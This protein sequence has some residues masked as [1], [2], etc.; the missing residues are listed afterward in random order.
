MAGCSREQ[1]ALQGEV[2]TVILA[3][4]QQTHLKLTVICRLEFFLSGPALECIVS[5]DVYALLP[6]VIAWREDDARLHNSQ[7]VKDTLQPLLQHAYL[8]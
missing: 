2:A 1:I 7:S 5:T 8:V 6:S 4:A 3:A